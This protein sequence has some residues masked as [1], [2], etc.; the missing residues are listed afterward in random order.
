MLQ[1]LKEA[2]LAQAKANARKEQLAEEQVSVVANEFFLFLFSCVVSLVFRLQLGF[3][4][5]TLQVGRVFFS[6]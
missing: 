6:C 1:L 4:R 5:Q 3:L 2:T